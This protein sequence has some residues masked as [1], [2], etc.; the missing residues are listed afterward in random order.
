MKCILIDGDYA[1]VG[2]PNLT[3]AGLGAKH[4]DRRNF[5][6][7]IATGDPAHIRPLLDFF[8][9][10]YLGE[11]CPDCRLRDVCPDPIA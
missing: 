10:F 11:F 1:F 5:E 7:G 9:R 2:S 4:P 3:G 6:A 8:D